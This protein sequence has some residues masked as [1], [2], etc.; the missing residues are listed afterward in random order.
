M[1]VVVL[2]PSET[3]AGTTDRITRV[4]A[5]SLSMIVSVAESTVSPFVLPL[6]VSVSEPSDLSSSV[7]VN[8]NVAV[9]LIACASIVSGKSET[10]SKSVPAVAVPSSTDTLTAVA[11]VS[12]LHRPGCRSP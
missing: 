8:V 9:P 3:T 10:V 6:T 4:D 12:A 11:L 1:T 2:A 5:A 7:G